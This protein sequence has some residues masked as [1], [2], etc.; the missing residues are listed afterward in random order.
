MTE[1]EKAKVEAKRQKREQMENDFLSTPFEYDDYEKMKLAIPTQKIQSKTFGKVFFSHRD[2]HDYTKSVGFANKAR[3]KAGS[4]KNVSDNPK[5]LVEALRQTYY[6]DALR[7][8]VQDLEKSRDK[9]L[10]E[11]AT[12][13]ELVN[14]LEGYENDSKW[15]AAA[16][17]KRDEEIT[18][19]VDKFQGEID[20]ITAKIEGWK[21][22]LE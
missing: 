19:I 10:S 21:N 16:L 8:M 13:L 17:Q 1:Q 14:G 12:S 9:F 3:E 7:K 5:F 2:V 6:I 20:R 15:N 11:K 18:A 4:M 22:P